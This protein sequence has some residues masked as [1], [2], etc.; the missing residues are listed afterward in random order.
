MEHRK[1]ANPFL[2][3]TWV[4]SVLTLLINYGSN[5]PGLQMIYIVMRQRLST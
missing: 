3:D 1:G 5:T 4:T 2:D